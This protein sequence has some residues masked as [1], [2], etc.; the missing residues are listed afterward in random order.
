MALLSDLPNSQK[1]SPDSWSRIVGTTD[2]S[3]YRETFRAALA[4]VE[5][6][7]GTGEHQ[8][9]SRTKL[10][11]FQPSH[12]TV[13]STGVSSARLGKNLATYTEL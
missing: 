2:P 6:I 4:F 10:I 3:H 5:I 8:V 13:V 1:A 12:E 11:N 7:I 9:E